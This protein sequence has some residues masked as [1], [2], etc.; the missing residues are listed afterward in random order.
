M[1]EEER[2]KKKK[3]DQSILEKEIY[4]MIQAIAR[5]AVQEAIDDVLKT[6]H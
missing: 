5:Q 2:K 3:K 4:A 6:F 1:T